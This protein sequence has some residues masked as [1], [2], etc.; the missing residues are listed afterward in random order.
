MSREE[1]QLH[2]LA[3]P[4]GQGWL[5]ELPPM[6]Q[7][8]RMDSDGHEHMPNKWGVLVCGPAPVISLK[9]SLMRRSLIMSA[10]G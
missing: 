2:G 7:S 3:S 10:K 8:V 4:Y 5:I 1:A 9:L 6:D